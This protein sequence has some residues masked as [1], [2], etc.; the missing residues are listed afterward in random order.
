MFSE[1]LINVKATDGFNSSY[2]EFKIYVDFT[3]FG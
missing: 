1:I 3:D 2:L